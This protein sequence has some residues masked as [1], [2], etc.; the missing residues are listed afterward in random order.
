GFSHVDDT[1]KARMV[2]VSAKTPVRRTARAGGKVLLKPE[3]VKLIRE[4]GVRKG[5]V[6]AVAK[7]AGICAAKR[8]SELI[9][10][11]HPI[12]I[13]HVDM[14]FTL[15]DEFIEIRSSAVCTHK[16]GIEMEALTAVAVAGLTIYD[17]CKAVDP[18]MRITDIHLLEKTKDA[19]AEAV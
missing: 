17:M 10:L 13:D 3:T 18:T 9:P 2:D 12:G 8:T 7:I 1:G 5:D 19:S 14:E 15:H 16:T 4:N 11:C 6:L